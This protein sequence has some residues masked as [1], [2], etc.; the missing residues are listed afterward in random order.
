MTNKRFPKD[1]PNDCPHLHVW[2]MS[3][4]DLTCVCDLLN[5]QIDLCDSDFKFMYCPLPGEEGAEHDRRERT[6][7]RAG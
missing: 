3:V 4:D 1:C 6:E 7:N 2:D 5:V